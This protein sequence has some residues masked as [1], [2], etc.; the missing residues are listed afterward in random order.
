MFFVFAFFQY[1]K[2]KMVKKGEDVEDEGIQDGSSDDDDDHPPHQEMRVER[3]MQRKFR[4]RR[5]KMKNQPSNPRWLPVQ[6]GS[7]KIR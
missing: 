3:M 4:R 6:R 5:R 2:S 1:L 7:G